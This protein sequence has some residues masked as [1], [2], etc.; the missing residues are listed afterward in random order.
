MP[1]R[2]SQQFDITYELPNLVDKFL[3]GWLGTLNSGSFAST[4]LAAVATALFVHIQEQMKFESSN[5]ISAAASTASGDALLIFAYLGIIVNCGAAI[6]SFLISSRLIET[7]FHSACAYEQDHDQ[8]PKE[9]LSGDTLNS[10][11]RRYLGWRSWHIFK[12]SWS[13]MLFFGIMCI[14]AELILY[15]WIVEPSMGVKISVSL[16][17]FFLLLPLLAFSIG[18]LYSPKS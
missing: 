17:S 15:L 3:Q 9:G 11:F 7:P 1:T 8:V 2:K 4:V 6:T 12:L 10:L 5:A 13:F 14:F 18:L 16:S